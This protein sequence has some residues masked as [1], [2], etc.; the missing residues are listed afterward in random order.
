MGRD[1]TRVLLGGALLV[2]LVGPAFGQPIAGVCED[3]AVELFASCGEGNF[4][5]GPNFDA[6][7]TL[8]VVGLNSGEVLNVDA[9]G[10]CTVA[11]RSGGFPGG[12]RLDAQGKLIITDRIGLLSYD[13]ATNQVETL[14]SRYGNE[15]MR[16]LNDSVIDSKG[17]IYFTEPY[18]SSAINKTGRVFYMAP[19][20]Q[21]IRLIGDTFA[22]PNGVMLSPDE[23]SLYVAEYAENRILSLPLTPAGGE[24]RPNGTPYV[25]AYMESGIGPDGMVV[26]TK[27]NLY[28]AHFRAAQ[29][30]IYTPGGKELGTIAM[31]EDA[32]V[33]TTNL[34]LH[35]GYLY[36]TE[37]LRNQ[38]WRVAVETQAHDVFQTK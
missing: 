16:G 10:T 36:I 37:A 25:F 38:I 18:G 11:G 13:T 21:S 33:G 1:W 30:V 35:D 6:Q 32:G 9:E 8:W 7:G 19:D 20:R 26:D 34:A 4:L 22:F 29:V 5:E 27:G 14:A 24:L 2:G 23:A 3:C 15:N 17:G 31:P 12:A 28:V